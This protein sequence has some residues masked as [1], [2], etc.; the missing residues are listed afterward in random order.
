M[1]N[2]DDSGN[3]AEERVDI[4]EDESSEDIEGDFQESFAQELV[5]EEK[6]SKG[7]RGVSGC[8]SEQ[9]RLVQALVNGFADEKARELGL[10]PIQKGHRGGSVRNQ[11]GRDPFPSNAR[12]CSIVVTLQCYVVFRK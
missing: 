5:F 7:H 10:T 1:T 6:R 9:N 12:W 11:S 2:T 8:P 4:I 3:S